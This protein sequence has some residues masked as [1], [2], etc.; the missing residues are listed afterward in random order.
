MIYVWCY[1]SV[2]ISCSRG[3]AHLYTLGRSP[4]ETEAPGVI[5]APWRATQSHLC[6][7]LIRWVQFPLKNENKSEIVFFLKPYLPCQVQMAKDSSDLKVII[8]VHC[9]T[10]DVIFSTEVLIESFQGDPGPKGSCGCYGTING[11]AVDLL[12]RGEASLWIIHT[13]DH[14]Q[15]LPDPVSTTCRGTPAG[16]LILYRGKL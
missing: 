1:K 7:T 3:H 10:L 13:T 5:S 4:C 14:L 11:T 12:K 15:K 9:V 8:K 16:F 6:H 2:W